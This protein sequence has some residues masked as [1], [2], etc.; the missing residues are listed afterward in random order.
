METITFTAANGQTGTKS[1]PSKE[2]AM[3]WLFNQGQITI[4]KMVSINRYGHRTADTTP[5]Q[6]KAEIQNVLDLGADGPRYCSRP[7]VGFAVCE[8]AGG[9][10]GEH[11]TTGLTGAIH[12]W[13]S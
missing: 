8:R 7:Y 9:H 4:T 12:G 10:D 3:D 11:R 1:F 6:H 5:E 13:D 2:Q